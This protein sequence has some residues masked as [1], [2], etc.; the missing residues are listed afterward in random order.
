MKPH[1]IGVSGKIGSGKDYFAEKVT[2]ILKKRGYIVS[3]NSFAKPLKEEATDL[4]RSFK[5]AEKDIQQ[6]LVTIATDFDIPQEQLEHLYSLVNEELDSDPNLTGYNRSE[7]VRLFLQYLG[8]DV[9]RNQQQ[10]YWVNKF[11]NSLDKK[12]DFI[13]VTDTRF[14][15]EADFVLE[16]DGTV[17]RIEVP[18]EIIEEQVRKRDGLRYSDK[19]LSHSSETALDDY[20]FFSI[21]I[22]RDFNAEDLADFVIMAKNND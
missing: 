19:A 15:N 12:S 17:V 20:E 3:S 5:E 13:F 14:P 4:F 7:G 16:Q 9:R 11:Y 6:S 10:N 1:L 2:G 18:E 22:G 21:V 8:T